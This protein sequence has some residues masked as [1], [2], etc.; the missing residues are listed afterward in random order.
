MA[1]DFEYFIRMRPV[2][3]IGHTIGGIFYFDLPV[4][5]LTAYLFHLLIR[6]PLSEQLPEPI[7]GRL[8]TY[9]DFDWNSYV[10]RHG[11]YLVMSIL[12]GIS[13]HILWDSFTHANGIF[14][15]QI[16]FLSQSVY[17]FHYRIPTY[18]VLQHSSTLAGAFV[19]FLV[20]IK[21][22]TKKV[23]RV[24]FSMLFWTSLV[25]VALSVMVI[26]WICGLSLYD[27]G[28]TIVSGISAIIIG[29]SVASALYITVNS[30]K[31]A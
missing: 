14:V 30:P 15:Q 16:E 26:R 12:I 5:F 24:A 11:F 17:L 20:F 6:N 10:L 25:V 29:L 1:P 3:H 8:S 23:P 31:H 21:L 27:Y 4:T 13:S 18:K 28:S 7:R 9:S 2:G 19:L 22:P